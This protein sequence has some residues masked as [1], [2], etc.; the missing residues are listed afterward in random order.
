MARE[1]LVLWR[2]TGAVMALVLL[3]LAL[4]A[5]A[6]S[7]AEAYSGDSEVRRISNKLQCPVCEGTS[8]ADSPS[9]V[10]EGMREKVRDMLAAGK[11]EKEIMS[12]FVAVYGDFVLREPPK[13]G[14]AAAVWWVP[15]GAIA[16]GLALVY[17]L[18]WRRR[19][20]AQGPS[21]VSVTLADDEVERYRERL[22]QELEE[23]S[24]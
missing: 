22:R 24:R 10:A 16:A 5:G 9:P 14:L 23:R 8:V 3:C 15:P 4:Y 1:T 6:L 12:F 18:V 21:P 7:H 13:T 2:R 20:G 19:K 11:S 17:L